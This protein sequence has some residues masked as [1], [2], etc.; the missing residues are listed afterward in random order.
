MPGLTRIGTRTCCIKASLQ[1]RSRCN[2]GR[3]NHAEN[4]PALASGDSQAACLE[5]LPLRLT[6]VSQLLSRGRPL[7]DVPNN[8]VLLDVA[9]Q[10]DDNLGDGCSTESFST[11]SWSANEAQAE[12]TTMVMLGTTLKKNA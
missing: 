10:A 1:T 11:L 7:Q 3:V 4:Q 2:L 8:G 5:G 6:G 9:L 12:F